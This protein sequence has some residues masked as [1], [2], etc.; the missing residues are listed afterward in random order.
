MIDVFCAECDVREVEDGGRVIV[1]A[2][3]PAREG[4]EEERGSTYTAP[5]G[6]WL[7]SHV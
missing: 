7:Y 1:F 4:E 5:C 6:V 3:S 2:V